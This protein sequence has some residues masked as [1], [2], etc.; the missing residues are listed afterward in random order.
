LTERSI[1]N[2][3]ALA[4]GV[5]M[6]VSGCT[7]QPSDGGGPPASKDEPDPS[8]NLITNTGSEPNTIDPNRA[9]FANEIEQ[10]MSVYEG[11]M[12]LDPKTLK[13]IPGAAAK[14]PEVSADGLTWKVTL[15]DGLKY[16]DGSPLLAKDFAYGFARTCD[17][18]VGIDYSFVLYVIAGCE[19]YNSMPSRATSAAE[20]KAARDR[21][22][23]KVN[24]DKEIVFTLRE[25]AAYFASI[26]YMWVGM[27][28]RESDV[29][30][31]GERWTEPPTYI[32]NGPFI[33]KEWKH[34]DR[35]VYEANP[36]YRQGKPKLPK[37][38]RLMIPE[39]QA[40]FA[41][42]RSNDLDETAVQAEDLRAVN[43]DPELSKQVTERVAAITFYYGFNQKRPPFND[44]NV[45]LAFAKSFDREAYVRDVLGGIGKYAN[46]GF[47]PPGIPGY[48]EGD[49]I[50]KF[51]IAA[52][53]QLLDKASPEARAALASIKF[54]YSS[55]PRSKTRAEWIQQ[56]WEKNLPGVK[57]AL[58]PVDPSAFATLFKSGAS[59]NSPQ[60]FGLTWIA[61]YP[62][63]QNFYTVVFVSGNGV[64][65]RR[66]GYDNKQFN[67][68]VRAADRELDP[69]KR[70]EMYQ[71]AGRMLSQ[72]APAAWVYYLASKFLRKPWV[73]GVTD[74]SIDSAMGQFKQ[75]E[76]YVTKHN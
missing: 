2:F 44:P 27:P 9:S 5:V 20:L 34:N 61:D 55:T 66:T 75:H 51:D 38:T 60:T 70:E 24:G 49:T 37:W 53:R 4:V 15:R 16:S 62:D 35:L 43:S 64:H 32:G 18:A 10:I 28:V 71:R 40:A 41:L 3:L 72:D 23:I 8:G 68:L 12:T 6:L 31:G 57:I 65:A 14:D 50:Q 52:A 47:I 73:K 19:A 63:Q 56:Q 26:L 25:P 30:K 22:G 11:L 21:L 1:R 58:D 67:D 39:G 69:K 46:G 48:D 33:L 29:Q 59:G 13:P 45:R 76:I 42:Y 17:P 7:G 36:N 74:S 54:T